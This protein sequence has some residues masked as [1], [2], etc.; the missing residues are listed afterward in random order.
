MMNNFK[1][2]LN[3]LL[4]LSIVFSLFLGCDKEDKKPDPKDDEPGTVSDVDGNIY[5]TVVFGQQEWMAENL[6]TTSYRDGSSIELIQDNTAWYNNTTGAF[7]WYDNSETHKNNY[8]GLYN[9]YAVANTQGLCPTGWRIPNHNDWTNLLNYLNSVHGL[10]DNNAANSLKSCRQVGSP[11]GEECNTSEHPRW[12]S[13]NEHFGTDDFGFAA[14]PGGV[15]VY[16][17]TFSGAGRFGF[18]WTADEV[19]GQAR[20]RYMNF[21]QGRVFLTVQSKGYG[22]SVRCIKE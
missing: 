19:D 8:G 21:D 1:S 2:Q 20:L 3:F 13:H 15:R 4:I 6:K 10:T 5:K 7:T 14:L 18:W 11:K 16:E 22:K 9:W 12:N 17:G